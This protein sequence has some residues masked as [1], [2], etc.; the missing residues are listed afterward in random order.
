MNPPAAAYTLDG[1]Y[2][3]Q[4]PVKR[5]DQWEM[6][7]TGNILREKVHYLQL[8][9]FS[10]DRLSI[11]LP[12]NGLNP[13]AAVRH[14]FEL[15]EEQISFSAWLRDLI[16][17]IK[18]CIGKFFGIET[19]KFSYVTCDFSAARE[20][21]PLQNA[22]MATFGRRLYRKIEARTWHIPVRIPYEYS[23]YQTPHLNT[24]ESYI[25]AERPN[26]APASILEEVNATLKRA[27]ID[28]SDD[29]NAARDLV[30]EV[31]IPALR[32][33]HAPN[34]FQMLIAKFP[35][36]TRLILEEPTDDQI[37]LLPRWPHLKTVI[38]CN[39][40]ATLTGSTFH[41]L[42][43]NLETLI[44]N[45]ARRLTYQAIQNLA[46][47]THLKRLYLGDLGASLKDPE[48]QNLGQPERFKTLPTSIEELHLPQTDYVHDQ[49]LAD[50]ARLDKLR[51][52]NI[53]ATSIEGGNFDRLPGT[54]KQLYCRACL[55][56]KA[57]AAQKLRRLPL[58]E[59]DVAF[60]E[61]MNKIS[62]RKI[63]PTLG[64]VFKT[65]RLD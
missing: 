40:G 14:F 18:N 49:D 48:K 30:T 26:R 15:F 6:R 4:L 22:L 27:S 9:L 25:E 41:Q 13:A 47:L 53:S 8:Q 60:V 1:S 32:H 31:H 44:I 16:Q 5:N 20:S 24:E 38:L 58:R 10:G 17:R 46:H 54:V 50:F 59:L 35:H 23:P 63:V 57:E 52:L 56:L 45:R 55:R 37:P 28:F 43:E 65:T 61:N 29:I 64:R 2:F 34:A 42:P 21:Q 7:F 33:F 62:F 36:V 3:E 12:Q 39:A 11:M 51:K 19:K